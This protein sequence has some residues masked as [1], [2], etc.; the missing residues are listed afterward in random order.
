MGGF[1]EEGRFY[2]ER[3]FFEEGGFFDERRRCSTNEEEGV[4]RRRRGSSTKRGRFFEEE[5]FFEEG[6]A[7]SLFGSKI[8]HPPCFALRVRRSKNPPYLRSS[9][10]K[11]EKHLAIFVSRV[12]NRRTHPSSIFKIENWVEDRLGP[13][14]GAPCPALP[15]PAALPCAAPNRPARCMSG[16]W[17]RQVYKKKKI[18][19]H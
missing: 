1:F 7:F 19:N 2:E 3:G 11:I 18:T 16:F 12:R 8:K 5:M 15:C 13:R 17:I 9:G 4:L 14:G 6:E 10:P